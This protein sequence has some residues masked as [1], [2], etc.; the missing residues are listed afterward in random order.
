[1]HVS[2]SHIIIIIVRQSQYFIIHCADTSYCAKTNSGHLVI[3]LVN[4]NVFNY[5]LYLETSLSD[6][7]SFTVP[8][9]PPSESIY[10]QAIIINSIAI[11]IYIFL[12]I[13]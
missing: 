10:L 1:M 4:E 6:T 5:F 3:I 12:L 2:I 8:V 13:S 7:D 9:D 11:A